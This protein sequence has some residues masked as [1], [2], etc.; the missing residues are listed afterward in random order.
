MNLSYLFKTPFTYRPQFPVFIRSVI[1][2]VFFGSD[3]YA[4][5]HL[6]ALEEH[7][8]QYKDIQILFVVT[9]S[10]KTPVA[11]HC[12]Q[13]K[14]DHVIWPRTL[15]N[16]SVII[17]AISQRINKLQN[18]NS[19]IVSF[20]RFLPS[21]IL[22]LFNYGC[23]NIHPS[24]LPRWKG[25]SPL[26]YTLLTGDK[27]TGITL[28]RLN[29]NH[30]TF[31][32]GSVLYQKS[33]R[34]PC[35]KDTMWLTPEQLATYLIPHSINAMFQ[36]ILHPNLPYLIGVDQSVISEKF[37]I[38]VSYARKP[39]PAMGLINWAKQSAQDIIRSWYAFQGSCVNLFTELC[40]LNTNI[41]GRKN[42]TPLV[43]NFRISECPLLVPQI[44]QISCN[45]SD[46]NDPSADGVYY[47]NYDSKI[48]NYLNEASVLLSQAYPSSLPPGSIVY[49]RS[50]IDVKHHLMPFIFIACRALN[51]PQSSSLVSQNSNCLS[52]IAVTSF[53]VNWPNSLANVSRHLTAIDLYNGY[54][55]KYFHQLTPSSSSIPASFGEKRNFRQLGIRCFGEFQSYSS[56]LSVADSNTVIKPWNE[57][58]PV[59]LPSNLL[60]KSSSP[61]SEGSILVQ[62]VNNR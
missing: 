14:I 8:S 32:S 24:L 57:L 39:Q 11:C 22:S 3:H 62:S 40:L 16:N 35:S 4:L 7:Q 10:E 44:N 48:M 50:Q 6:H 20:G 18:N 59:I 58:T 54:F 36:V 38:P 25:S 53:L 52:W 12:I 51:N 60:S 15:P 13:S 29:P 41:E 43:A 2:V 55:V 17:N 33:L 61:S 21:S 30:T 31:D 27:V 37:Q 26:L 9:T 1:S 47:L 46:E 49:L 19:I 56:S 28:F 34:L 5:P 23:F 45:N 42:D